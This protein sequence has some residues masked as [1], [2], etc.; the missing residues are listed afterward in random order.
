MHFLDSTILRFLLDMPSKP[1]TPFRSPSGILINRNRNPKK[2]NCLPHGI[3]SRGDTEY[4]F[5]LVDW[6]SGEGRVFRHSVGG[7]PCRVGLFG[8]AAGRQQH[9]V[10]QYAGD[11]G[12]HENSQARASRVGGAGNDGASAVLECQGTDEQAHGESNAAQ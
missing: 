7:G 12:A 3:L 2:P 10:P 1:F 9:Q 4:A 8:F 11:Q 5:G 6:R